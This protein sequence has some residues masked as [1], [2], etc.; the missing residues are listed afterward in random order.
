MS[1]RITHLR[2]TNTFS[3][4]KIGVDG[5]Q[6]WLLP[7]RLKTNFRQSVVEV[8]Y[9]ATNNTRKPLAFYANRRI[10]G[11]IQVS[12]KYSAIDSHARH[13]LERMCKIDP[14]E[15]VTISLD[16][17][18]TLVGNLIVLSDQNEWGNGR[19]GAFINYATTFHFTGQVVGEGM[20]G[21]AF[22]G[23][24]GSGEVITNLKSVTRAS[25]MAYHRDYIDQRAIRAVEPFIVVGIAEGSGIPLSV[26]EAA[27]VTAMGGAEHFWRGDSELPFH[28]IN[29]RW[30]GLNLIVGE[31]IYDHHALD[32]R[33]YQYQSDVGFIVKGKELS[34]IPE[35]STS[36][37]DNVCTDLASGP[38]GQR[39]AHWRDRAVPYTIHLVPCISDT[40]PRLNSTA[41]GMIGSI[42]SNAVTI[43]GVSADATTLRFDGF[44]SLRKITGPAGTKYFYY[45]KFAEL[46][47]GWYD[48]FLV[49]TRMEALPLEGNQTL[50]SYTIVA[51]VVRLYE[52][53]RVAFSSIA[54]LCPE[55]YG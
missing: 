3:G 41:L 30:A 40:N 50:P 14:V 17:G 29:V 5:N 9:V 20:E 12:G 24:S 36:D 31:L 16:T 33:A 2:P 27:V 19:D 54:Q 23:D 32:C 35:D 42:N 22:D 25:P 21:S 44:K 6:I 18:V 10:S 45:L 52:Y 39:F 4:G 7:E 55:C 48:G 8:D 11:T 46:E 1:G 51:S 13:A 34:P 49:C 43:E 38:F 53:D 28:S 47:G 15:E 37:I 26:A